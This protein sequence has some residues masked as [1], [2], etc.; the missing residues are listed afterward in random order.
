[1]SL[2]LP[3]LTRYGSIP[4]SRMRC[5]WSETSSVIANAPRS[6]FSSD[7]RYGSGCGITGIAHARR[8]AKWLECVERHDPRR[9]RRRKILREE[10]TERLILPRLDVAR[11]PV[12]DETQAEDVS[13]RLIERNRRAERVARWR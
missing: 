9:D 13:L 10:R 12:V 11:R 6:R 5:V 3:T 7:E 4:S 1:M 8:R 2:K